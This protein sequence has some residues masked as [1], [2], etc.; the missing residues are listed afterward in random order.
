MNSRDMCMIAHLPELIDA[1]ITSFKIE[2]RMKSAYYTAVVTNAYRHA[3]DAAI[4]GESLDPVWLH[5][6]DM[7]SHRPYTTG[8]YFGEPGQYYPD[9]TYFT[10]ADVVAVVERCGE[11]GLAL[12]T[13]R[14]KLPG[15]KPVAFTAQALFDEEGAPIEDTRRA[16]MPFRMALPVFAP[17]GSIVRKCR[18]NA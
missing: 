17:A 3:L 8:F 4:K 16:M 11:T 13:Q 15:A 6:T 2:G 18:G 12:L 1:G 14:N 5:E 9:A 10:E 7:V